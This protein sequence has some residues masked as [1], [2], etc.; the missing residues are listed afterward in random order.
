MNYGR[1]SA[2]MRYRK[3]SSKKAL[4]RKRAGVRLFGVALV[5]FVVVCIIGALAVGAFFKRIIDNAP[6][7]TAEDI[8]PTAHMSTVYANDGVTELDTFVDAGSNRIY[9]SIDEIPE[10]L[11]NAFIA[12]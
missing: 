4:K 2:S 9:V 8:K 6:Q 7:I 12:V 1:T 5:I 3:I 10:H 11:Q